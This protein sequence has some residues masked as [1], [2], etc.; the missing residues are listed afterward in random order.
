[1]SAWLFYLSDFR[2]LSKTLETKCEKLLKFIFAQRFP[3]A[4]NPWKG[5]RPRP[6]NLH[7][8][9]LCIWLTLSTY[10]RSLCCIDGQHSTWVRLTNDG[11]FLYVFI[12]SIVPSL[13]FSKMSKWEHLQCQ[14]FCCALNFLLWNCSPNIRINNRIDHYRRG[15]QSRLSTLY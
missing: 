5:S 13:T 6:T 2:N 11:N 1:M 8:L 12:N 4:K 15:K 9:N 3:S 10:P 14:F 7:S